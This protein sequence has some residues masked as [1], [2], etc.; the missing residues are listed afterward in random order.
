VHHPKSHWVEKFTSHSNVNRHILAIS[1]KSLRSDLLP[2]LQHFPQ[3]G[4]LI[5]IAKF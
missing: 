3:V 1:K 2:S 4:R 5:I